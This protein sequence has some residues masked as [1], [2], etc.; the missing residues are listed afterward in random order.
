[1]YIVIREKTFCACKESSNFS[2]F[3]I[4]GQDMHHPAQI[5]SIFSS[6]FNYHCTQS[7]NKK[8]DNTSMIR[9]GWCHSLLVY[10]I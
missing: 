10:L 7:K 9:K 2:F 5:G 6:F 1:M 8:Y 4:I 3:V